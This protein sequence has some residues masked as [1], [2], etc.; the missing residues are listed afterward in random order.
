MPSTTLI[1]PVA[2]VVTTVAA[3]LLVPGPAA[4]GEFPINACQA[5]RGRLSTQ[6]FADFASR[7]M[8]I[9]RACD[10]QGPGLRGLITTN[11]VR[12]A[13]LPRGAQASL[14]LS[15]PPGTRLTRF[16]WSGAAHRSDCRYTLE[17]YADR[18]RGPSIPIRQIPANRACSRGPGQASGWSTP[19]TYNVAGATR[20]VQRVVCVSSRGRGGCSARQRN[21]IRTF[22]AS[23]TVADISPP[24]IRVAGGALGSGS[25]VSGT[26]T[27]FY[28]AADNVGVRLARAVIAGRDAGVQQRLCDYARPIPCP[29]GPGQIVVNTMKTLPEGTSTLVLQ[30]QDSAGNRKNSVPVT[31]RIDNTPPARIDASVAGGQG[32]RNS[33]SFALAWVNPPERDR[34]PIAAANY[35]LCPVGGGTCRLGVVAGAN[36]ARLALSVP[37]PGAWNLSLWR[38]DAAGNQE[39]DNASVPVSL[40]YDPEPPRLGFE[41]APLSDPTRVSVLVT[42]R[43]SGLAGGQIE[44]GRAHV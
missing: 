27:L 23:A 44:I 15:A 42:D 14:S 18:P 22:T 37:A 10:P 8:G 11:A 34:A 41:Q 43:V 13:D 32:W 29:N 31:A 25:W 28:T 6:A 26:Q 12:R 9:K 5:D 21:Y 7:G 40:R 24:A 33:N 2:L 16:R 4:A 19:R 38:R 39:E 30:A 36:L 1:R 3:G 35:K 20:I 17:V